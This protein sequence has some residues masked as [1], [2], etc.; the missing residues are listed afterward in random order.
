MGAVLPSC[1]RTLPENLAR[2]CLDGRTASLAV[3]R[4]HFATSGRKGHLDVAFS[5]LFGLCDSPVLC[6]G[7]RGC[8]GVQLL[9]KTTLVRHSNK[10]VVVTI[11]KEF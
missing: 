8:F 1:C 9:S 10:L 5:P 2:R 3:I 11:S 7:G 4:A 6:L